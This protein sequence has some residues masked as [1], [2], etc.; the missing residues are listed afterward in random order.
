MRGHLYLPTARAVQHSDSM[1]GCASVPAQVASSAT[2]VPVQGGQHVPLQQHVWLRPP[3]RSNLCQLQQLPQ[4]VLLLQPMQT[5]QLWGH[6]QGVEHLSADTW[7]RQ[8][9]YTASRL[10]AQGM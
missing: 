10:S 4:H 8:R 5:L 7:A 2:M 3:A 6:P 9:H 1:C